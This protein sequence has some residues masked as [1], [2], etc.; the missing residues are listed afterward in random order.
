[1]EKEVLAE[2]LSLSISEEK[3]ADPK[4]EGGWILGINCANVIN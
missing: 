2:E 3:N 1:V 4:D